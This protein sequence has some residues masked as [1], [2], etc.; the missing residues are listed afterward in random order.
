M[1]FNI[2]QC[3]IKSCKWFPVFFIYALL[4]WSYYAYIVQLCFSKYIYILSSEVN[5]GHDSSTIA[6]NV[7][8]SDK[9]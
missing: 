3:L 5:N 8:G 9:T 1:G 2:T 7:H 6:S 4:G